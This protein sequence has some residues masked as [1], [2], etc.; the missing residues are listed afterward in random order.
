MVAHKLQIAFACSLS[1]AIADTASAQIPTQSISK[2][3]QCNIDFTSCSCRQEV[4]QWLHATMQALHASM[5]SLNF[6][7]DIKFSKVVGP[8]RRLK[9]RVPFLRHHRTRGR[10]V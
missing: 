3:M 1:R 9:T 10:L 4:E 8:A 7:L 5:Q 6:C 2:V